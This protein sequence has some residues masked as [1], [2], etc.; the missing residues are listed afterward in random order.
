MKNNN[1][2]KR[3]RMVKVR[4]SQNGEQEGGDPKTHRKKNVLEKK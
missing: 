1:N 2:S 3:L 4:E